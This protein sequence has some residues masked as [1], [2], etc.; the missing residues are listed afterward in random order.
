[1][2]FKQVFSQAD[3]SRTDLTI[4]NAI[5][6]NP[7]ACIDEGIRAVSVRCHSSP[8]TLVRLAKKLGFR[9]Y[10]ELVYFIKFNLVMAPAFQEQPQPTAP[11][12]LKQQTQFLD[13]LDSGKILIHGSGFSQLVAQ[14]MYNKFMTL[15]IDSYLSLWP[16]FEILDREMRFRFD[17]VIVISK[18]GNS[19]SALSWS[20]AVKRNNIRLAAFCGDGNSPLAQQADMT[21]IYEDRQ[22]YDHDIYYPNPFFGHCLLGFEN[23]I[24]AWFERRSR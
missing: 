20:D 5:F 12:S 22:K 24:K 18:S 3:L 7:D 16:D 17:M 21:F 10:L 11:A 19:S 9:G 15:G 4:L 14:Y 13:L 6:D 1:V 23:L 2:N 8:S